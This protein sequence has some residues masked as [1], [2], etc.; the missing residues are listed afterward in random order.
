MS[1]HYLPWHSCR[2]QYEVVASSNRSSRLQAQQEIARALQG[3][4][5]IKGRAERLMEETE[6]KLAAASKQQAALDQRQEAIAEQLE[7]LQLREVRSQLL[8]CESWC[9]PSSYAMKLIAL[10]KPTGDVTFADFMLR[11]AVR[12]QTIFQ[13]QAVNGVSFSVEKQP[14]IFAPFGVYWKKCSCAGGTGDFREE[15]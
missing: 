7:D 11:L 6:E 2:G 15:A 4:A 3:A 1:P 10:K 12:M 13:E 5:D 14:C 9:W 8:S